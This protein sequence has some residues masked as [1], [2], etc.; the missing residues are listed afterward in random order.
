MRRLFSPWRKRYVLR[1]RSVE[2][3]KVCVFCVAH[4]SR[5][6]AQHFVVHRG[7][8][9]FV[10]VNRFPYITGHLMV[11]PYKHA[12][13]LDEIDEATRAEMMELMNK[14]TLVLT[15]VY[16]PGGFNL[17]ANL[18]AA[19]GAGIEQHL[20]LHVMPRWL[21]DTNFIST[22]GETRVLPELLEETWQ[23]VKAAW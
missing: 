4:E 19:A 7:Q 8:H 2:D 3:D 1:D 12:A 18:G 6:D 10:L 11:L 13:R 5:D 15:R 20:H 22:I 21:G 16:Q 17:G 9:S 23:R 14:A